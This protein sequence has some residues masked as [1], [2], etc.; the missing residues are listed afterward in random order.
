MNQEN[1][2]FE[3]KVEKKNHQTPDYACPHGLVLPAVLTAAAETLAE[4]GSDPIHEGSSGPMAAFII[5][6]RII[7]GFWIAVSHW[8]PE[9]LVLVEEWR[10]VSRALRSGFIGRGF[11]G[12]A[13]STSDFLIGW[14]SVLQL[15]SCSTSSSSMGHLA[16]IGRVLVGVVGGE[17]ARVWNAINEQLHKVEWGQCDIDLNW[18]RLRD[19]IVNSS[20]VAIFSSN[21]LDFFGTSIDIGHPLKY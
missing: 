10:V 13:V 21:V 12:L 15:Q 17:T 18:L 16:S 14:R 3:K 1:Q 4:I 6:H 8:N 9:V 7:G 11:G 20:S 2:T 5:N 19:T